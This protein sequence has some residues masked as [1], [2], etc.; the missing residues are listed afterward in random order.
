M[1]YRILTSVLAVIMVCSIPTGALGAGSG[2]MVREQIRAQAQSQTQDQTRSQDCT[3]LRTQSQLQDQTKLQ[4]QDKIQLRQRLHI[5]EE[6]QLQLQERLHTQDQNQLCF[7]DIEQHWAREQIRS[8]NNWG[9]INGNPDGTFNPDGNISGIEGTLMIANMMNCISGINAGAGS[10][11]QI[12]WDIVPIW[13]RE[14]MKETTTLHVAAQN[15]LYGEQ[16]LNRLNFAVMLAKCVGLEP[17]TASPGVLEFL[18][19]DKIP[20]ADLGYILALRNYGILAGDNG[21]FCSPRMVSRAEA[22]VMLTKV[23]DI[24][25]ISF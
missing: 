3:Q 16:N 15:Q 12:N 13:A 6:A 20:S 9:L 5:T 11:G 2:D 1:N 8:A 19:Q 4:D 23:L 24:L 21:S 18:D 14:R 7:S 17:V 22:A 10:M 25:E